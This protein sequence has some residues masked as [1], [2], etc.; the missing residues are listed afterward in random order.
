MGLFARFS[1]GLITPKGAARDRRKRKGGLKNATC[2]F[3]SDRNN[4][5][6][7]TMNPAYG[8]GV[9]NGYSAT[10]YYTGT[11]GRFNL[12]LYKNS[13]GSLVG[14]KTVT[15]GMA[16]LPAGVAAN[17]AMSPIITCTM[18]GTIA[19]TKAFSSGV[20]FADARGFRGGRG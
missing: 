11:S 17:A 16:N 1:P 10:L 9:G 4:W 12:R 13:D 15:G 8:G 7:L 14:Q 5:V 18:K 19:N 6:Q 3:F 20:T 2:V